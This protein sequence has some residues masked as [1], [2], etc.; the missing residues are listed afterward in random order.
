MV[1][2]IHLTNHSRIAVY[3][4]PVPN[5]PRR[6]E[7]ITGCFTPMTWWGRFTEGPRP[8]HEYPGNLG[9]ADEMLYRT[10]QWEPDAVVARWS[11]T[12]HG[13]DL[14]RYGATYWFCNRQAFETLHGGEF[15]RENQRAVIEAEHALYERYERG[16]AM[17]VTLQRLAQFKRVTRRYHEKQ[18]EL[19]EVWEDV[20]SVADVYLDSNY[21][22]AHVAFEN[23]HDV[24]HKKER[25]VVHAMID[26]QQRGPSA[27]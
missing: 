4:D 11:W 6:E 16:D 21:T 25:T 14:H 15:S 9:H 27:S 12:F 22:E 17:I 2:V 7:C 8:V 18:K 3:Q 23:F 5:D 20:A 19:L 26:S 13:L 10:G 1:D 24:L